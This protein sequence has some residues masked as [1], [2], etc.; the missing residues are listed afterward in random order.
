MSLQL[1]VDI[2]TREQRFAR[3]NFRGVA[4]CLPN[5][6]VP[7]T[8]S[9]RTFFIMN[10]LGWPMSVPLLGAEKGAWG[11]NQREVGAEL[12][13]SEGRVRQ[14]QSVEGKQRGRGG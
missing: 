2:T 9:L 12:G 4:V 14:D 3:E 11:G 5:E 6:Y 7:R 10:C 8:L 13:D 1:L